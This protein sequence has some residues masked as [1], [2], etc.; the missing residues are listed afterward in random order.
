MPRLI[1]DAYQKL[2]Y[3]LHKANQDYG[4]NQKNWGPTVVDLCRKANAKT[5]LD[6]GCGKGNLKPKLL[7]L[8]P[9]LNVQEYDPAIPGK[10]KF[11]R[12][13]EIIC[14]LDVMEHIEPEYLDEVLKHIASLTI[15]CCLMRV[16]LLL[17]AKILDDGRN[18]HLILETPEWWTERIGKFFKIMNSMSHPKKSNPGILDCIDLVLSPIPVSA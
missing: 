17:A 14:C 4:I 13:A 1:S 3:N 10:T 2:N 12:L 15:R 5:V 16:S 6:Y 11:P 18:A 7:A 9:S 8:A